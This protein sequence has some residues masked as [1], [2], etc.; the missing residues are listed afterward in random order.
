MQTYKELVIVFSLE[1][2]GIKIIFNCGNWRLR[3][4]ASFIG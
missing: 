2:M 3:C 4:A 1:N